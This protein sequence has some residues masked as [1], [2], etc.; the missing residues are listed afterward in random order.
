MNNYKII[1]HYDGSRYKG[2]QR[3][4]NTPETIQTKLENILKEQFNKEVEIVGASR[5]DA[6]VHS[7]G[8][9][10][11]FKLEEYVSTE[12]LLEIFNKYLPEDISVVSVENVD[13]R[14][15]SRYNVKCK[16]Y[17]YYIWN[18][19]YINP[20]NRKYAMHIN[21]D[22]DIEKMKQASKYFIGVKDFTSYSTSSSKKKS[23]VREINSIYVEKQDGLI[24]ITFMGKSFLYNMIRRMT[25]SLIEVGL[26]NI[27]PED[28]PI[29]I[30][31]KERKKSGLIAPA[32]GLFLEKIQY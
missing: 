24:K 2:W 12:M 7:R 31:N 5:T 19:T 23:M 29:I 1:V 3:L 9:T 18:E 30:N 25:G 32:K 8:Q 13:E 16:T 21:E 26:G 6:G 20:F 10:A 11:N 28:I 27:E 17:V 4:G 14:F 15:H 22:L